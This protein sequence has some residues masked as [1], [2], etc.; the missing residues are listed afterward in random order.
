MY[1][2]L[3]TELHSEDSLGKWKLIHACHQI[4]RQWVPLLRVSSRE[5]TDVTGTALNYSIY[6]HE[7]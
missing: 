6:K 5:L 4:E 1:H 3:S 2:V 7:H